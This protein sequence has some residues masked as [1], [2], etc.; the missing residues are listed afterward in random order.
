MHVGEYTTIILT[1]IIL[2]STYD[3]YMSVTILGSI[4]GLGSINDTAKK[5]VY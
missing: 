2:I 4:K 3:E 1:S 5:S